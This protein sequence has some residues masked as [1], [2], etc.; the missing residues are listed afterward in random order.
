[1]VLLPF[2]FSAGRSGWAIVFLCFYFFFCFALLFA[3]TGKAIRLHALGGGTL[4]RERPLV[5]GELQLV[6]CLA[7]TNVCAPAKR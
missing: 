3:F 1:M 7:R 5:W 2:L 4:A 6:P